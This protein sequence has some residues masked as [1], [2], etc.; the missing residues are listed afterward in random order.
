MNSVDEAQE[1]HTWLRRNDTT[2]RKYAP[3]ELAHMAILCGFSL[4]A[5]CAGVIDRVT[6]I[7]RL[8]SFWESPLAEKWMRL[9]S[10]DNGR[11]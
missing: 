9:V 5:S 2:L 4:S 10:Y 3:D 11:D 1:L 6:L 8:I 7:R